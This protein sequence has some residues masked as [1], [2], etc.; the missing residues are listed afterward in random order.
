M[1][2]GRRAQARDSALL[3][4]AVP[5]R[6]RCGDTSPS[7]WGRLFSSMFTPL[8]AGPADIILPHLMGEVAL[9]APE[10]DA[11]ERR[12]EAAIRRLGRSGLH[13]PHRKGAP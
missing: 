10:A 4:P 7:G 12:H 13:Q 5:L 2:F 6:R 3:T 8:N 11:E 1:G 9:V